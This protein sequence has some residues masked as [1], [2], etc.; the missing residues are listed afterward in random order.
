MK[1]PRCDAPMSVTHSYSNPSSRTQRLECPKCLLV[2]TTA[3][4]IVEVDPPRGK[5]ARALA[6]RLAQQPEALRVIHQPE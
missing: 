1:C 2:V 3:T 4:V 5:G 6:K